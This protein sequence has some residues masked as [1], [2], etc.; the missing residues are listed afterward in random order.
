VISQR[1]VKKQKQQMRWQPQNA[2]WLLQL[3]TQTL[4]DDLRS[5]FEGWYPGM[6]AVSTSAPR[7]CVVP[8]MPIGDNCG[9]VYCRDLWHIEIFHVDCQTGVRSACSK[10]CVEVSS[11]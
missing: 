5:T 8:N 11:G 1:F 4:N 2:H 6:A 7:F 9:Y 10:T 3:R